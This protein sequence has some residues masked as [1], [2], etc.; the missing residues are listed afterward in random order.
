MARTPTLAPR[1]LY[2]A[3]PMIVTILFVAVLG[4]LFLALGRRESVLLGVFATTRSWRSTR[5][6]VALTRSVC[7]CSTPRLLSRG[8]R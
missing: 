4:L 3:I 1:V 2:V 8:R 6:R 5:R 7:G